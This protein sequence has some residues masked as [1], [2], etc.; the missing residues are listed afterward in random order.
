MCTTVYEIRDIYMTFICITMDVCQQQDLF[1]TGTIVCTKDKTKTQTGRHFN[2]QHRTN[3]TQKFY[4][5]FLTQRYK[6]SLIKFRLG[7]DFW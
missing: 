3:K 4:G 1:R 5:N 2:M 7:R 6:E